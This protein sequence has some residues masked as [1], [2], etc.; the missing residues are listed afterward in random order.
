[1]LK[2]GS[3]LLMSLAMAGAY[4]QGTSGGITTSTDPA[5]AAAIEQHAQELK[6]RPSHETMAEPAS[7]HTSTSKAKANA[8]TKTP[9]THKSTTHKSTTHKSTTHKSSTAKAPKA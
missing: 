5:K 2:T 7:K 4:A 8:K 9:A 6:A 1:M 3:I